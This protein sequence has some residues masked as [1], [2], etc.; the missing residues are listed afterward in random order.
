M[1]TVLYYNYLCYN[2]GHVVQNPADSNDVDIT[3]LGC[4]QITRFSFTKTLKSV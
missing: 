2:G 3:T 1:Y 4:P